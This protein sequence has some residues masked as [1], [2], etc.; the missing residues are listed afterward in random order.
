MDEL[1]VIF[2]VAVAVVGLYLLARRRR[3]VVR[4]DPDA[5]ASIT[6]NIRAK[7]GTRR[8]AASDEDE[9]I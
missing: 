4:Q 9:T 2:V 7:S 3:P 8:P 1:I 6:V 5:T